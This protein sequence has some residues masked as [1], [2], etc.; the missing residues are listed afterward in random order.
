MCVKQ[1]VISNLFVHFRNE[2]VKRYIVYPTILISNDVEYL[3]PSSLF[4]VLP[5]VVKWYEFLISYW[6]NL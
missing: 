6:F 1:G 3:N 2:Q 5:I 4:I